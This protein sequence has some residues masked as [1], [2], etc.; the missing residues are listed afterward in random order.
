MRMIVL[1]VTVPV[2]PNGY[3]YYQTVTVL[4][5]LNNL[6][7]PKARFD[8]WNTYPYGNG[9]TYQADETFPMLTNNV[10]LYAM[11]RSTYS[12]TYEGNSNTGGTVPV[13]SNVYEYLDPVTVKDNT[14][15]LT[16]TNYEFWGWNTLANTTGKYYKAGSTFNISNADVTLYTA[17][18]CPGCHIVTYDVNGA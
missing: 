8:G 4:G 15:A 14:G 3:L 6:V 2:D 13:D 1:E 10:D 7:K 12:V 11:W 5:N 9:T 18:A 16:R 17:W